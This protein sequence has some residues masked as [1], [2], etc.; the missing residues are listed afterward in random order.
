M[1]NLIS[2][3]KDPIVQRF[4][5]RV[6]I[7]LI[8]LSGLLGLAWY[9]F[10]EV[11]KELKAQEKP[12]IQKLNS[13]RSQVKFLQQ[14]VRL[15][16]QYGDK[17]QELVK[18]GLVK[19]QD[20][21]FWTDSLIRLTDEYLIPNLKFTFSAEK[22]LSSNQFSHIKVPNNFFFYSKVNLN[23]TLQHEEDL[24]RVLETISQ[25][26]S[27]LYLVESCKT[28]LLDMDYEV[29]ANFDLLKGNVSADCSLILFHTHPTVN[30]K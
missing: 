16:Q 13:Q 12:K 23:M 19:Q 30:N 27:P 25:K 5:K 4:L 10:E 15:Y 2:F 24:L 7:L 8:L 20:R 6:L 11:G 21:V 17:Y 26:V 9:G 14:Q 28:K 18:K 1:L 29:N 22:P 3:L